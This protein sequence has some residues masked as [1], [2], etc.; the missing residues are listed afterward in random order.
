MSLLIVNAYLH[1]GFGARIYSS[2]Y[3]QL[4]LLAAVMYVNDTDLV[5]WSNLPSCTP[6][7]LIAAAQ[8]ATYAWGGLAIATGTAMK[9]EKCYAYFLSYWYDCGKAKLR[10]V[11]SLP[12]S[13]TPITLSLGEIAP[14]HLMVLLPDGTSAP[15]PTLRNDHASLMLG[16]YFGPTSGGGTHIRKNGKKGLHMGRPDE[17]P[18]TLSQPCMEEFYPPT[19]TRNDVGH[20]YHCHV[21]HKLLKQF[22]KV[23]FRCLP[24]LNVN[25]HIDLPWRLIPEHYQGLGIANYALSKLSYLQC[26]YGFEASHSNALMIGYKSFMVEVGFL[27]GN[28]MGYKYKMHSLL[29]MSN[30]WFKNVW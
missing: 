8:T 25:C 6:S 9:Q 14:S 18:T 23:Y 13:I 27:Y 26:N 21:T 7:K 4:L 12:K 1:N 30:T 20:R 29:A 11:K 10:T 24:F 2:Y 15:I 16:I 22:Q 3:K 19:S 17:I 28:T 5:H